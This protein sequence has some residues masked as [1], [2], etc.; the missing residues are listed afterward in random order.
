MLIEAR[1]SHQRAGLSASELERIEKLL[2][3]FPKPPLTQMSSKRIMELMRRDKKAHNGRVQFV[4]LRA[5][6]EPVLCDA[7]DEAEITL[8]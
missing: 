5:I 1:L 6:G 7:F 2:A 4:L 8:I 3:R